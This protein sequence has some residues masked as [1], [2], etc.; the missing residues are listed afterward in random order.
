MATPVPAPDENRDLLASV[1]RGREL[2]YGAVANCVKCHGETA[3][4]D[5]QT[6]DYDDWNKMLD[7]GNPEMVEKFVSLGALPPRNIRPRNLRMGVFR[8]GHRPVDLYW[9]VRNG[10][11][12]TPMPGALM[13]PEGAPPEVKGLTEED[14]WCL[15]DYV[16]QLPYEPASNPRYANPTFQR[17]RM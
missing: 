3:L 4:G 5:G 12:G 1:E 7:P 11:D 16:R 10:I 17:E 13:K 9:R 2:F 8:G 6:N 14:L 15:I